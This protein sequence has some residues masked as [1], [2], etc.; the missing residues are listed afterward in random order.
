MSKLFFIFPIAFAFMSCTST[1][2]VERQVRARTGV[3]RVVDP[4]TVITAVPVEVDPLPPLVIERP[5]FIPQEQFAQVQAA[6]A[7]TGVPAAQAA[8]RNIVQPEHF[9]NSAMVFDFDRDFVFEIFTQPFR[10]TN[11]VLEAGEQVI[12]SPFISDSERWMLGAGVSRENG[13]DVQHIYVKPTEAGLQ[14]TLRNGKQIT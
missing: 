3:G 10:I 4:A 11:I 13:I 7:L 2:D 1:I 9:V 8:L 14:A 12:G 5:I 6:A